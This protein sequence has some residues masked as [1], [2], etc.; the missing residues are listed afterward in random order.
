MDLIERFRAWRR[1]H[2][3][4]SIRQF[5]KVFDWRNQ[6]KG[7]PSDD[8]RV[9]TRGRFS[10]VVSIECDE[11]STTDDTEFYGT[12]TCECDF[13][14]N[15]KR[16]VAVRQNEYEYWRP[17]EGSEVRTVAAFLHESGMAKAAAYHAAL[18]QAYEQMDRLESYCVGQWHY[19]GVIVKAY[20]ADDENRHR[21]LAYASI[22]GIESDSDRAYFNDTIEELIR[23]CESEISDDET[24]AL[25]RAR[26]SQRVTGIW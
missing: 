21:E 9:I 8:N 4:A 15:L 1:E 14:D 3:D 20:E 5:S 17:Q 18:A 6:R 10:F 16:R 25:N 26:A 13:P 23:E 11:N 7:P 22:W 12:F 2:P 24:K 19:V